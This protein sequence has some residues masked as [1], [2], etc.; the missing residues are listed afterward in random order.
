MSGCS[1]VARL[2]NTATRDRC[3]CTHGHSDRAWRCRR[4]HCG[5]PRQ[6]RGN[7]RC[8]TPSPATARALRSPPA[9]QD[10]LAARP[11]DNQT[12]AGRSGAA[13]LQSLAARGGAAALAS[14]ARD[15]TVPLPTGCCHA[16]RARIGAKGHAAVRRLPM[17][18]A[19]PR[20]RSMRPPAA[21]PAPSPWQRTQAG[22]RWRS[23]TVC[24]YVFAYIF[25]H[26]FF[27]TLARRRYIGGGNA[28]LA[29]CTC[30]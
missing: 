20:R 24:L 23:A 11:A 7:R 6:R 2:K 19:R 15:G 18:L 3:D 8:R 16:D 22:S 21:Q 4:R 28:A 9:P 13:S 30:A 14:A 17:A 25:S 10:W 29:V 26:A 12:R 5:A 27:H 1:R